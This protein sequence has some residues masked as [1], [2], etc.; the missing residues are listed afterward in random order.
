MAV[1]MVRPD[2]AAITGADML[3]SFIKGVAKGL[4]GGG[5]DLLSLGLNRVFDRKDR[6][7]AERWDA[8]KIQ[9][10]AEDARKAGISPL[11]AL[12]QQSLGNQVT[13]T[14]DAQR[15]FSSMGQSRRDEAIHKAQIENVQSQTE[16][17][18]AE[19]ALFNSQSVAE[20]SALNSEGRDS[21]INPLIN[22]G[23]VSVV[24]REVESTAKNDPSV[25]AGAEAATKA[26]VVSPS[27]R[28]VRV[29]NTDEPWENPMSYFVAARDIGRQG[30]AA[31]KR[32]I[33][34][35]ASRGRV[36][37]RWISEYMRQHKATRAQAA[38]AFRR[39]FN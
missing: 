39:K 7:A 24:P 27:G 22:T 18:R 34:A 19:A 25:T 12:G 16:R 38:A 30:A 8:T 4:S 11:A 1:A 26:L 14:S 36:R 9:R 2:T 28:T 6:K 37:N 3:G 23:E 13:R 33:K 32:M 35:N 21:G 29:A 31:I 10:L 20:I 5:G 15:A 17:N